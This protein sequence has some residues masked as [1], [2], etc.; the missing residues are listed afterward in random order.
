MS[1]TSL[2][3]RTPCSVFEAII[4]YFDRVHKR[5]IRTLLCFLQST[6]ACASFS[7]TELAQQKLI[8]AVDAAVP[9]WSE[10]RS[11]LASWLSQCHCFFAPSSMWRVEAAPSPP[12]LSPLVRVAESG[13]TAP[14]CEAKESQ[15][16]FLKRR[17]S[18]LVFH[19]PLHP[20]KKKNQS[21][22]L[23]YAYELLLLWPAIAASSWLF[24]GVLNYFWLSVYHFSN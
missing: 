2:L 23:T 22:Q 4:T 10:S 21:E 18:S 17:G 13:M 19:F 11:R 12:F 24:H 16:C 1:T 20:W 9:T 14:P 3:L 6:S 7:P 5:L 15:L 8:C